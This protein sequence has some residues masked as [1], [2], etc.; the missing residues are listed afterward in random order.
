M[1]KFIRVFL[2]ASLIATLI[3]NIIL[4]PLAHDF[5]AHL[6][7]EH[8]ATPPIAS[9][10]TKALE[11]LLPTYSTT[12]AQTTVTLIDEDFSGTSG[13]TPPTGWTQNR[14]TG[15]SSDLWR[16]NNPGGRTL[17]APISNPAAIFDSDNYSNNSLAEN[18]AL[19]SPA[20]DATGFVT[21][22][23][24]FDHYFRGGDG[25]QIFVEVSNGSS[26]QSI[27]STTS[28]TTNP[29]AAVFD[30]SGHAAGV[31]NAQIRF[32]WT[33][34][35]S[36]YWI[37][38]NVQV[39]GETAPIIQDQIQGTAYHDYNAN[40][41]Q[42]THEPG[43]EG[44]EVYAIDET[45]A[46]TTTTTLSDGTYSLLATGVLTGSVRI[47]FSLPVDN[48]LDYLEPG[49]GTG[50]QV[51][52]VT[53][54]GGIVTANVGYNDP[55][56]Y[57]QDNPDVV[58]PILLD[59]Q[60]TGTPS[61]ASSLMSVPY[62]SSGHDFT[63]T[64]PV[65]RTAAFE[66]KPLATF[67]EL[68]AT[69][70]IA[71]QR[72]TSRIYVGAFHKRYSDFGP[73]GPDAIYQVDPDGNVTGIIE[74]DTLL[75]STN[76]AGS[77]AHDFVPVG[78]EVYDIGTGNTSFD[79]VGKRSLGDLEISSDMSI[80]YVVNLF[81]RKIYAIDIS[82]GDTATASILQ[83]WNAPDA[84]GANR[85]RPMGLAWHNGQLW[86]GSVDEDGSD[87]YIHSLD[88]AGSTFTLELTVPLAFTRQDWLDSA[89]T[90]PST[91]NAWHGDPTTMPYASTG[92][93]GEIAYPQP[94]LTDLEFVGD[95]I[96]LGFRDRFGDQSG[97][98]RLFE[99]AATQPAWGDAAGDILYACSTSS[100]Y[101][102][103]SGTGGACANPTS[104]Q[105]TTP[106]GPGGHEYYFW[107]IWEDT[108]TWTP[109]A[110]GGAFHWETTQGALLQIPGNASVA[111]TAMD[112]FSDF[113]AGILKLNN[114]TG[115]REGVTGA[116]ASYASLI[117]GY[118]LYDTADYAGGYP[119]PSSHTF[120]KANGL[121]DIEAL[122]DPAPIE[123]GNRV[124]YDVNKDGV[125]DP[126][127]TSIAG[128]IVELYDMDNGGVLVGTATTD[129]DGEYYFGGVSLANMVT[130]TQVVTETM[131]SAISANTDDAQQDKSTGTMYTTMTDIEVGDSGSLDLWLGL[132]FTNISVPQGAT[133]TNAYVQFQTDDT[134]AN[135]SSSTIS[136]W[137][138]AADNPTTFT[139]TAYNI[140]GRT[141]TAANVTG[142]SPPQWTTANQRGIN[143]QTPD[144]S[145]IIQEI[146]NRSGWTS[147]NSMAILL[148]GI[149]EREAE[150]YDGNSAGAAQLVIEYTYTAVVTEPLLTAHNYEIR[151]DTTQ[152]ALSGL[153]A[154]PV[155]GTA[156]SDATNDQ[157]DSDGVLSG[158]NDI[159]ALT[160]GAAGEN[161]HT[162]DFGFSIPPTADLTVVKYDDLDPM[163]A[164]TVLTYT[165]VITNNGPDN[166]ESVIITDTLPTGTTFHN[167]SPGCASAGSTVTCALGDLAVDTSI[168][169]T[170]AVMV[171]PTMT[172]LP[173]Q[174]RSHWW[175]HRPTQASRR[176]LDKFVARSNASHYQRNPLTIS[177][178]G[179][180]VPKTGWAHHNTGSLQA[181]QIGANPY[182]P[183]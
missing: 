99:P 57:C 149:G 141:R 33:G 124:W 32:R 78:G 104:S 134:P 52:F 63:T 176:K 69:Y 171:D 110:S 101:V 180:P 50:T 62:D 140:T 51:Q 96:V 114:T 35:W 47:E 89:G 175:M 65:T 113:S 111:T 178:R 153:T 108:T 74:L 13:S 133:I 98:D 130:S 88:P 37:V 12:R 56:N 167:A 122:C 97:A 106:S 83:S 138:Q 163:I 79:G 7:A 156:N 129:A 109:G 92:S 44:I 125:Q 182:G 30:I 155:G 126:G 123:I 95:D 26:W 72:T 77:D 161:D 59:G 119:T 16:F 91:W 18:V 145:V 132:R 121:G 173:K 24:E 169:V 118:T 14:I 146:V 147:G 17:N 160:T 45:G 64:N 181:A 21:V 82:D 80:L 84:T 11:A 19:Q 27:Y 39:I 85:H 49:A 116:S 136:I 3:P 58:V 143:Q 179:S 41:V 93:G 168:S 25:G 38:D 164:G 137:G 115:R 183:T 68:G 28:S 87:A 154:S 135:T 75:A 103:E 139:S 70:G 1:T 112:P 107:D 128:V 9:S 102:I 10:I 94:M 60:H 144:I 23:L 42:D 5:S 157:H 105:G 76:S 71:W 31:S 54:S 100:G 53:L 152:P 120:A 22:T 158:T 29:A 90:L 8:S 127:E 81:D 40:G 150:S 166:A 177:A 162:F 148:D 159:I 142:W 86:V 73:K 48:S 117:G 170:I 165:I 4:P 46:V 6:A 43:I 20:F 66:G 172:Y 151:I 2:A 131:M 174:Q 36:W 55:V 34:N 61:S 67:G 15:A